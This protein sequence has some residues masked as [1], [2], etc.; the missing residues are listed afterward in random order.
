MLSS[1]THHARNG[2]P[3]YRLGSALGMTPGTLLFA[4]FVDS[5]TIA[6]HQPGPASAVLVIV[7]LILI[8]LGIWLGRKWLD[9]LD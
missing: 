9:R 7:T 4:A 1:K 3:H 5:L 8:V 6:L 2:R